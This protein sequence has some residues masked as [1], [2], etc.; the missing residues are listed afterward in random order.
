[1]KK[2]Q[3]AVLAR[4]LQSCAS[5]TEIVLFDDDDAAAGI[6]SFREAK[7]SVMQRQEADN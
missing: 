4:R 5:T 2:A 3:T 7:A 1:M 6:R